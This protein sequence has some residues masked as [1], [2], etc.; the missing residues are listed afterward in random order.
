MCDFKW[1]NQARELFSKI[2]NDLP[3][4]H[5]SIAQKLVKKSAQEIAAG[6]GRDIVETEVLIEAF[7]KEVPPAYKEMMTRLFKKFDIDYSRATAGG[8]ENCSCV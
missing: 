8:G 3:Q 2:I 6:K 5:R 4:F 1:D 7:F